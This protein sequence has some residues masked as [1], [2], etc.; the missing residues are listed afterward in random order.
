MRS[1][2][3]HAI[4]A[5]GG[6]TWAYLVWTEEEGA[7][8]E[9]EVVVL[10]CTPARFERA[11]LTSE[12][13]RTLL[14]PEGTGDERVLWVT[15]VRNP[16]QD[17]EVTEVFVGS[18]EGLAYL[19]QLAP[20]RAHRSLGELSEEQLEEV[21]LIGGSS[22][23]AVRCGG[24]TATFDLGGRAFGSGDRYLRS[25]DGGPVFLVDA[26]RLAG[27]EAPAIRLMQRS[28]HTFEPTE[29]AS[30]RVQADGAERALVQRNRL[31]PQRAA[32]V[33]EADPDRRNELYGNWLVS[34]GRLRVMT[35]L[36]RD[37]APE[38]HE[39]AT[40]PQEE[41]LRLEY[42]GEG[43][44]ELGFL[45]LVRVP[46][47]ETSMLYYARTEATKSWV[48]VPTSAAEEVRDNVRPVVG[49]EPLEEEAVEE[50]DAS[51]T[52]APGGEESTAGESTE[53]EDAG[54]ADATSTGVEA[55]ADGAASPAARELPVPVGHPPI[56]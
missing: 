4:L 13:K 17:N 7:A 12:D 32:W 18:E 43:G 28:L 53:G 40:G 5:L 29:V 9:E 10:E 47:S 15:A 19:E 11:E 22:Q 1:V 23:L 30:L 35:Y 20:L 3:I 46:E 52:D 8:D 26:E 6:L 56:R 42:R 14:Q 37:T 36:P 24:R 39:Q 16:G 41:I 21:E 44:N 2:L 51:A 50:G 48:Q 33:D 25:T 38:D 45:E 54:D 55:G 31:D 27:L 49:L 34:V